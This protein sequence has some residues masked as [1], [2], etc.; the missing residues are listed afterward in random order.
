MVEA[1][2]NGRMEVVSIRIDPQA[3]D[4]R[5]VEM[6]QDLLVSAVNQ[7]MRNAQRMVQEEMQLAMGLPM[8]DILSLLN[9][10]S[11]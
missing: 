4:R 5:D 9:P 2:V 7:A 1:V 6:L 10:S 11:R 8:G 3:V